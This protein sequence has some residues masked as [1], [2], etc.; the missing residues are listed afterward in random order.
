MRVSSPVSE[1]VFPAGSLP[2]HGREACTGC[3]GA[4]AEWGESSYEEDGWRLIYNPMSWGSPN[5]KRLVLGFSKG[6]RQANEIRLRPHD[7][8]PFRG[9][10]GKLSEALQVL[11]LLGLGSAIDEEIR[12]GSEDW[13]FGS[14]VRCTIEKHDP[15]TGKYLKSGDV[16]SASTR[17]AGLDWTS[18]CIERHLRV[19]PP[20]LRT[21]VMLSNDDDYVEACFERIQSIHPQTRRVN[22]VAYRTGDVTWVHIVHVGGPG[23]NHIKAWL[24]GAPGKQGNKMR[25]ARQ[26]LAEAGNRG[27]F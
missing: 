3:F 8:V 12:A 25:L 27:K 24:S 11:G 13:A 10:R 26:A 20:R 7:E 21:V 22:E 1:F 6:S 4:S 2:G 9:F 18:R 5:P 17:R 19:L 15:T 23:A 16:I 14:L